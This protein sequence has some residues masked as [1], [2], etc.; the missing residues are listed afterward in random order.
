MVLNAW[1]NLCVALH[2]LDHLTRAEARYSS[3]RTPSPVSGG[4]CSREGMEGKEGPEGVVKADDG[5]KQERKEGARKKHCTA[6]AV[7]C[8]H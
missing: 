5:G 8:S 6:R 1:R 3:H 7:N 4:K 2:F